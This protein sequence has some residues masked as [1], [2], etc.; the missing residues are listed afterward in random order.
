MS[1]V[2]KNSENIELSICAIKGNAHI[3]VETILLTKLIRI[4]KCNEE[5]YLFVIQ[6]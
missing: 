6:F 5:G 1:K 3:S 4:F 2:L